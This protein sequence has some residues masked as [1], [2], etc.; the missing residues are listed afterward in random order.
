MGQSEAKRRPRV[1]NT[2][3]ESGLRSLVILTSCYPR[4]LSLHKLVMLD[5]LVVHTGDLEGPSS[6][7]PDEASRTAELFVRRGLVSDGLNLMGARNLVSRYATSQGFRYRAGEEAGSFLD[8]LKSNYT[9]ELKARANWLAENIIPQSDEQFAL[10]MRSR[11]DR[12][13]SEFQVDAG[14]QA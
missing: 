13:T 8:L 14:S 4:R 2:A 9:S 3:F 11:M 5:H 1:F 12:W 10:F 7:H 6:L